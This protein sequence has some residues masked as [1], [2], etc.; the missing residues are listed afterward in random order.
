[1]DINKYIIVFIKIGIIN[2]VSI[3]SSIFNNKNKIFPNT[4]VK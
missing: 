2:E 1:M 3:N 4:I